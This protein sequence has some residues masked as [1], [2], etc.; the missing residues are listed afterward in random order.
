[1]RNICL[2]SYAAPHSSSD[3]EHQARRPFQNGRGP[4]GPQNVGKITADL[5]ERRMLEQGE[6]SRGHRGK[7]ATPLF[8]SSTV[9]YSIGREIGWRQCELV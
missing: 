2:I 9:A 6:V 3:T 1:M 7:P 4:L 8:V 5:L